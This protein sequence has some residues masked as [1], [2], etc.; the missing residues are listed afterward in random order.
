[1][2]SSKVKPGV[3]YDTYTTPPTAVRPTIP[4]SVQAD[5]LDVSFRANVEIMD[6]PAV[7]RL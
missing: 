6:N 1:M 4:L 7:H 3:E 5:Q 2:I